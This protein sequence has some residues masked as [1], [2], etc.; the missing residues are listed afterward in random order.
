MVQIFLDTAS[1]NEIE[2]ISSWGIIDGVTTNQKIFLAEGG[3]DFRRRVLDICHIVDGPISI[4]T[5]K[6]NVR[7]LLDEAR[8]YSSWHKNIV[9]KVAMS[10]NGDGLKV[11]SQLSKEG[12]R[13]NMT[14]MMTFNQ[15]VLATKAGATYVSL[16]YNRSREAGENPDQ[17]IRD[18]VN[19]SK[20]GGYGSKLIVGSIRTP[21]D[22]AL[23]IAAGAHIM[24]I[25]T[26]ILKAMPFNRRTEETI[27]EFDRAWIDFLAKSAP[28]RIAQ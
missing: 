15:L 25:P 18:Y 3:V 12:I 4:E 10:G 7:D 5:T 16:F 1:L 21:T 17:I 13:T 6:N 19:F 8:E 11:V 27:E 22:V 9:I 26:K 28:Q 20:E 2:E 14:V 23:A 24:T